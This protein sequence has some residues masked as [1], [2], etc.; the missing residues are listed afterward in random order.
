MAD[1]EIGDSN[2][3]PGGIVCCLA[4]LGL[5]GALPFSLSLK[6]VIRFLGPFLDSP[7]PR[8]TERDFQNPSRKTPPW[9]VAQ[10]ANPLCIY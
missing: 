4:Y 3:D 9:Q 2:G 10:I 8:W 6:G 5:E 1:L 7:S